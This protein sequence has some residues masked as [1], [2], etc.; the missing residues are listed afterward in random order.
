MSRG[1]TYT[2]S[3][4]TVPAEQQEAFLSA[5]QQF[6]EG[7]TELGGA[8]E[9]FILRDNDDPTRFIV[10][11]RWDSPEAVARWSEDAEARAVYGSALQG[12]VEGASEAYLTTKVADLRE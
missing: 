5:F 8:N 1:S 3:V 12:I 2:C 6:A 4:W 7:A 9:G 11:R 10:I